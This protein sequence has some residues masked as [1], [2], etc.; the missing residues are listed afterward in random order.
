M[1]VSSADPLANTFLKGTR[2]HV[3]KRNQLDIIAYNE[4]SIDLRTSGSINIMNGSINKGI[5]TGSVCSRI[6][7]V[8]HQ[9]VPQWTL[10]LLQLPNNNDNAIKYFKI[11]QRRRNM[12]QTLIIKMIN[13]I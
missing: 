12:F 7:P 10:L 4:D 2:T 9:Y 5:L 3:V 1:T 8:L 11:Y 6:N 13:N